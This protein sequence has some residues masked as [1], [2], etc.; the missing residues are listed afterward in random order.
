M[1]IRVLGP[2]ETDDIALSPRERAILAA[3]VARRGSTV[4]GDELAQAYWGD[5]P[6]PAS[7]WQQVKTAITR[8]RRSLGRASIATEERGYRLTAEAGPDDATEFQHAVSAAREDRMR[9]LPERAATE[10]RRALSLWR[11]APYPELDGWMPGRVEAQRLI[12]IRSTIDEELAEVRL[13]LGEHRSLIADAERLVRSEP[14][15]EVRWAVLARAQYLSGRPADALATL[16][17]ARHRFVT[18]LGLDPGPDLLALE[19]AMLRQDPTLSFAASHEASDTCPYRG[20]TAFGEE[21]A[22]VFFGRS[23]QVEAVLP[24]VVNGHIVTILGASGNGKSSF[25]RAGLVPALRAAGRK[26]VF[27]RPDAGL[28]TEL[29]DHARLLIPDSVVVIDQFEEMVSLPETVREAAFAELGKL[30]RDDVSV[31]TTL[32]SDHLDAAI[33]FPEIGDTIG[34]GLIALAPLDV[35]GILE[36]IT[37][38]AAAAGLRLESGLPE[39]ILRDAGERQTVLPHLSHALVETW[40]RREGPLLT[41]EGYVASGGLVGAIAVTAETSFR[42]MGER[43]QAACRATLTRL[44]ERVGDDVL[45][46]RVPVSAFADD[47][48]RARAVERLIKARLV[49]IDDSE[50]VVAHESLSTAWPRLAQWLDEDADEAR[51]LRSLADGARVWH[52]AGRLDGD[53]MRGPRLIAAAAV[54]DA[55]DAPLTLLEREFLDASA[56]REQVERDDLTAR[57]AVDRRQNRRLRTSLAAV[58]VLTMGSLIAAGIAVVRSSDVEA[59]RED[60][61]IEALASTARELVS[62]DRDAAALLAAELYRRFPGDVRARSALLTVATDAD[63]VLDKVNYGP[64]ERIFSALAPGSTVMVIGRMT[65]G[66]EDSELFVDVHDFAGSVPTTTFPTGIRVAT[67]W[68][69]GLAGVSPDQRYAVVAITNGEVNGFGEPNGTCCRSLVALID[70]ETGIVVHPPLTVDGWVEGSATFTADSAE[71]VFSVGDGQ[72][73]IASL[74]SLNVATGELHALP[75]VELTAIGDRTPPTSL[76]SDGRIL[77]GAGDAVAV[78]RPPMADV[79]QSFELPGD[80]ASRAIVALPDGEMLLAGTSGLARVSGQGAVVWSSDADC[81]GLAVTE[82][83]FVCNDLDLWIGELAT[84]V[85]TGHRIAPQSRYAKSIDVLADGTL[86]VTS[87]ANRASVQRFALDGSGPASRLIARDMMVISGFVDATTIAVTPRGE[88]PW[89]DPQVAKE[90]WNVATDTPLGIVGDDLTG[91][92]DGNYVQWD[93]ATFTLTLRNLDDPERM[94]PFHGEAFDRND[95]S[96]I[97]PRPGLEGGRAFVIGDNWIV[98]IDP[99]TG[100][101][102]G[103]ALEFPGKDVQQHL[104]MIHEIPGT[105]LAVVT[106]GDVDESRYITAVFNLETGEEVARGLFGAVGSVGLPGGY[107]LTTTSSELRRSTWDLAPIDSLAKPIGG[108][109]TFE[110]SGDQSTLL[111]QGPQESAALYDVATGVKLVDDIPTDSPFYESAHI[112]PDARTLVTNV[113]G[114]VLA[115]SLDGDVLAASACRSAGRTFTETEWQAYFP[116]EVFVD[117]CALVEDSGG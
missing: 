49:V 34:R 86:A 88:D 50:L 43:E 69:E 93:E 47:P 74:M 92:G 17:R 11:G 53:L 3:L 56:R 57:A 5:G 39:L 73:G 42:A 59:A 33:R 80:Y 113:R 41:V 10:Y 4:T 61:R 100:E 31:V 95:T 81:R 117:T 68:F 23:A 44:V 9:G 14:L 16:R 2:A 83:L 26:V 58:A 67:N 37:L 19:A 114:G 116:G 79:E 115:L 96:N 6:L 111:L 20:L 62:S 76:A 46:R 70:L 104:S 7:W 105:G 29:R 22:R 107:V 30:L 97:W 94:V 102:I 90:L 27:A 77:I 110:L 78:Y 45:R 15:R 12:E 66:S 108:A 40:L 38:P 65:A 91:M 103:P 1:P 98:G 63:A 87:G 82:T 28:A 64:D 51:V 84:G 101:Q 52:D 35:S 109:N 112:S 71:A 60:A 24:A 55:G 18:D 21:D 54:R 32:R 48:F 75:G 13:D 106:W 8:L 72:T 85:P 36:A 89:T 99:A 25:V